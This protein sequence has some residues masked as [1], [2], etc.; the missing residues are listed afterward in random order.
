M[1]HF[2]IYVSILL[3]TVSAIACPKESDCY[4]RGTVSLKNGRMA[5][6]RIYS[7]VIPREDSSILGITIGEDST[8]VLFK[9]LG[10]TKNSSSKNGQ[11]SYCYNNNK[12]GTIVFTVF[13]EEKLVQSATLS[14]RKNS[15]CRK[16]KSTD[17]S[18]ANFKLGQNKDQIIKLLG[19][20][21]VVDDSSIYYFNIN[22]T[23]TDI[24]KNFK[25]GSSFTF[26]FDKDDK[27]TE[28]EFSRE[29]SCLRE[30]GMKIK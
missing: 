25:H 9:K 28:I 15:T 11:K 27:A 13:G 20:P 21:S 24:C 6:A 3:S 4:P 5:D 1:N 26:T 19:Q 30:N 17:V 18:I 12:I 16:V 29:H 22:L 10:T 8:E 7:T 2:K 23:P 14:G